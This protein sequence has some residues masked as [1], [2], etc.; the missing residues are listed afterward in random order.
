MDYLKLIL[1]LMVAAVLAAG[2]ECPTKIKY[3]DGS[4][5]KNGNNY[6][7]RNGTSLIKD[8]RIY[9]PGGNYLKNNETV[10]YPNQNYLQ[11]NGV[12]YYPNGNQL[13]NN[14]RYYYRNGND[15]RN[16]E[17]FYYSNGNY[18]RHNGKLYRPDGSETAFPVYL[19]EN[20]DSYGILDAE[21]RAVSE[22]VEINFNGTLIDTTEVKMDARWNGTTFDQFEFMIQTGVPGEEVLVQLLG[23]MTQCYLAG[24]GPQPSAFTVYGKAATVQVKPNPGYNPDLL[25]TELQRLL[26]SLPVEVQ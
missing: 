4:Y 10:Y 19:T 12:L 13:R 3:P 25:K 16:G 22:R 8:N 15:M 24:N 5:L 23:S 17:R 14:D 18:A 26:D 6:Y 7:Y 2:D 1:V 11:H 21:V 20:I 9:Y